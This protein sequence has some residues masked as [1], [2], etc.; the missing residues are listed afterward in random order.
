MKYIHSLVLLIV[1]TTVVFAGDPPVAVIMKTI[2]DVKYKKTNTDWNGAKVGIP[3]STNDEIKTGGKSLALIKFTDNSIIRV[4][5]NSSLKIY[6]DKNKGDL[7]KNTY[8]DKG[9]VGFQVTKQGN[10]EFKFTTPTMVASIRGTEGYF[11][12]DNEGQTL[13]VCT[14]GEIGVT[15]T[16]GDKQTGTVTGGNF[17]QVGHNGQLNG[18]QNTPQMT[19]EN[20]NLKNQNIKR[21][22]IQTSNGE[23][24]I[25]YLGEGEN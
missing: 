25:E 24:I 10:D 7:S 8:I 15:A 14:D 19:T 4:R 20:Q 6:A 13:L 2:S 17:V 1:F 16:E 12:V 18:G 21:L 3:L 5:E 9:K 11:D 23:L 22:V